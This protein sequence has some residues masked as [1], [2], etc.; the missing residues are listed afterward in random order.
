MEGKNELNPASYRNRERVMARVKVFFTFS[1]LLFLVS[2]WVSDSESWLKRRFTI[3]GIVAI[4]GFFILTMT[5]IAA[6]LSNLTSHSA[7]LF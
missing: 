2:A 4:L 5:V 1:L 7:I 6:K 3:L